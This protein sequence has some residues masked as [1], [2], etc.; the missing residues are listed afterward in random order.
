MNERTLDRQV[1][2]VNSL[3][4]NVGVTKVCFWNIS[5]HERGTYRLK[6]RLLEGE[7]YSQR[8]NIILLTVLILHQGFRLIIW[9]LTLRKSVLHFLQKKPHFLISNTCL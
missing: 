9:S 1:F 5:D 8:L 7:Q 2:L 6:A 4:T 3:P